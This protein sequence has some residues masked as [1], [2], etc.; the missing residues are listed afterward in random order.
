M[1]TDQYSYLGDIPQVEEV[2]NTGGRGQE[3]GDNGLVHLNCRLRHNVTNRLHFF[4]ELC[5]L[6]VDHT[7]EYALDLR[8]LKERETAWL[9]YY[10]SDK[11]TLRY[12]QLET[13]FY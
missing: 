6:L 3:A 4:F 10:A 12:F 2:V 11:L 9:T 8:F 1:L 5:Q 7:A 13:H